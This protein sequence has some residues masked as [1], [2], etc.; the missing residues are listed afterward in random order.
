MTSAG[1]ADGE[2]LIATLDIGS[3]SVRAILSDVARPTRIV[4]SAQRPLRR[5]TPAAGRVEYAPQELAT[6][7]EA[8]LAASAALAAARGAAVE[9]AA[10]TCQRGT[11]CCWDAREL[12]RC[13]PRDTANAD[14][15][16]SDAYSSP[17]THE[18]LTP[19]IS[20]QDTRAAKNAAEWNGKKLKVE[21]NNI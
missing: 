1:S 13:A 18:T 15:S 9:A 12:P 6:A 14:E 17:F 3:T 5:H 11:F 7:C 21:D 19:F 8:V 4:G 2:R 16:E 10:L 20:W